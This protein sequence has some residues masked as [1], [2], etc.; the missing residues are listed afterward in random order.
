[1]SVNDFRE[2]SVKHRSNMTRK[3]GAIKHRKFTNFY[4]VIRDF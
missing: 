3:K 4:D 2:M 1:M